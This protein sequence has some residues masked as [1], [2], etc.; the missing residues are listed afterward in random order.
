[1]FRSAL[2]LALAIISSAAVAHPLDAAIQDL[3]KTAVEPTLLHK[4]KRIPERS[5][6]ISKISGGNRGYVECGDT[7]TAHGRRRET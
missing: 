4:A 6:E 7:G 5:S 1:M 2:Y 3:S